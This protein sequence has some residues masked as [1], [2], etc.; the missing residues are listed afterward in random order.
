[1][2]EESE[3]VELGERLRAANRELRKLYTER[4]ELLRRVEELEALLA[5]TLGSG[6]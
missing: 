2:I 5:P 1:V 4:G 6:S 3:L